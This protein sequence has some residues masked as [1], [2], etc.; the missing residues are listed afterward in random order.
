MV[1]LAA[2]MAAAYVGILAILRTLH[3]AKAALGL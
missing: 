1:V 3:I 2:V